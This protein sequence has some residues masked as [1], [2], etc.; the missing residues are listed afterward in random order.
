MSSRLSRDDFD[1]L[2]R[3]IWKDGPEVRYIN[4]DCWQ[5]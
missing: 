2:Y 4:P 3:V 1:M 5:Y